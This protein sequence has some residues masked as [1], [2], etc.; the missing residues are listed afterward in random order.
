MTRPAGDPGA[1]DRGA[2]RGLGDLAPEEIVAQ[3]SDDE[4]SGSAESGQAGL[5]ADD[6]PA[7]TDV[8][9]S[10][11]AGAARDRAVT[12]RRRTTD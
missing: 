4:K 10:A 6:G 3:L 8:G 5:P 11:G 9:E 1:R 12:P 2:A 7:G